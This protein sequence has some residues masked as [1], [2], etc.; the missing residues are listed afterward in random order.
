MGSGRQPRLFTVAD[1]LRGCVR[2]NVL[3]Y[4]KLRLLRHLLPNQKSIS[5]MN[6]NSACPVI[7]VPGG[8]QV[9]GHVGL[10]ALG[11]LAD[12]LGIGSALSG[13]LHPGRFNEVFGRDDGEGGRTLVLERFELL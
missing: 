5:E 8:T 6:S 7:V 3:L 1:R 4:G 12:R 13:A 10:H 9:V 2:D 11:M